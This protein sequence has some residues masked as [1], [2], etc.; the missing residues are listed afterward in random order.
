MKPDITDIDDV[1]LFVN[2]F[3]DRIK[4]DE[5][6]A[7]I[8][9]EH[10]TGDWQPHL[11][12]MYQ[13][14]NTVLFGVKDYLGNPFAKH[15]HMALTENHFKRWLHHFNLTIDTHFEGIVATDAKRRAQLMALTFLSRLSPEGY[16]PNNII[17]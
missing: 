10:I 2:E 12:R 16:N 14:W 1:K 15:A 9:F 6:L 17:V 5:L 13:F 11:N 7:P 3:Y 4:D 8:F